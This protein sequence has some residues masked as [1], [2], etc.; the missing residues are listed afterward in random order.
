MDLGFVASRARAR[1]LV[2]AGKV[3]IND[4]PCTK[5]GT[6]V[7]VNSTIRIKEPD[8]PYVSRGALKLEKAVKDFNIII[9]QK[10]ALDIG[11][12]TGGFTHLLLMGDVKK[13]HC[14]DV[15]ENILDWKIRSDPRVVVHEKINARYLTFDVIG[16]TVDLIV[17]DVSF[18]SLEKIF[19]ACLQFSKKNTDWITLIKPQFEVGKERVSRGGIVRSSEHREDAV[20]SVKIYG[21][22]NGLE[23]LGLIKSPIVGTKGNVE[24]LAHW[25]NSL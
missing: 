6:K 21:K 22:N 2:I 13:V 11:S 16:E 4:E 24:Y 17:I 12:S 18:I 9:G 5:A 7:N 23:L 19:P 1:A 15:G 14:V 8:H 10:T 20:N 25:K 3:L